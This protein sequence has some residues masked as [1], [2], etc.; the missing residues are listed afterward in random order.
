MPDQV[1][2]RPGQPRRG[3]DLLLRFLDLVFAEVPLTGI[4]CRANAVGVER[5]GDGNQG[6]IRRTATG[7]P[8]GIVDARSDLCE[9]LGDR[10]DGRQKCVVNGSEDPG[11]LTGVAWLLLDLREDPF[12]LLGVLARRVELQVSLEGG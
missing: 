9:V 2:S 3:R 6:D 1:P 12:G 7:A 5:L 4:P 10:L 11:P 8:G